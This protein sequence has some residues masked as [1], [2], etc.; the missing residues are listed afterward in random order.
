MSGAT[1]TV[2]IIARD[3]LT[4]VI[5][6]L[7]GSYLGNL[8][9]DLTMAGLNG[10]LGKLQEIGSSLTKATQAQTKFISDANN[11]GLST[12]LSLGQAEDALD[13]INQTLAKNA[14]AL[15]GTT[16]QY[17]K[18]ANY[19][20]SAVAEGK[21]LHDPVGLAKYKQQLGEIATQYTL[22]SQAVPNLDAEATGDFVRRLLGG[23]ETFG[24]L[25]QLQFAQGNPDFQKYLKEEL[26]IAKKTLDDWTKLDQDNRFTI[27]Q[28][29]G[30]R[31]G[32]SGYITRLQGT[33]DAMIEGLKSNL[34]DPLIGVFGFRREIDDAGGRT[35]LDSFTGFLQSWLG[36]GSTASA[37]A[38]KLG[39]D[40]D[41]LEPLVDVIDFV[42]DVGTKADLWLSSMDFSQGFGSLDFS[43]FGSGLFE[44]I[45][46]FWNGIVNSLLGV[47][48]RLDTHDLVKAVVGFVE[49][50]MK[51]FISLQANFDWA[52]V[53]RFVGLWLVKLPSIILQALIKFNW[54]LIPQ[55]LLVGLVGFF[56]FL[57]GLLL[58]VAQGLLNEI[59]MLLETWV[60]KILDNFRAVFDGFKWLADKIM[61][62]IKY[63]QN[64]IPNAGNAVVNTMPPEVSRA[65]EGL[66]KPVKDAAKAVFNPSLENLIPGVGAIKT[67]LDLINLMTGKGGNSSTTNTTTTN[68]TNLSPTTINPTKPL[69]I[70]T[71]DKPQKV[72]NTFAPVISIQAPANADP[73]QIAQLVR[74]G[75]AEDY[76][77][78]VQGQLA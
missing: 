7:R 60:D 34:F 67:G 63:A 23:K 32:N 2:D 25:K 77:R 12:G 75:I 20:A 48:F 37:I 3:L 4:P 26:A 58:G 24:S 41:P 18:L 19:I 28:A 29:V 14:A 78:Y 43:S 39:I 17:V 50:L 56:K 57:G 6:N 65:V 38:N 47:T 45:P 49:S 42:T 5:N 35:V 31:I 27:I 76:N 15:P 33:A 1:I 51:G 71:P 55:T 69:T 61:G 21:N 10:V 52:G 44:G 22:I 72:A 54:A 73:H 62:W 68:T 13:D 46:G 66:P 8:G 9:A 11:L 40:F 53:G 36:L 16:E 74:D 59:P 70:P 64:L 30:K